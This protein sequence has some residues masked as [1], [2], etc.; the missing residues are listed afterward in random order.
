MERHKNMKDVFVKQTGL[1]WENGRGKT[2]HAGASGME[3]EAVLQMTSKSQRPLYGLDASR[4]DAGS[5]IA[6]LQCPC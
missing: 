2:W 6:L 3:M 1:L 5:G 4:R